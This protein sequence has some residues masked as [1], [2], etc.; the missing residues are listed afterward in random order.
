MAA[1]GGSTSRL[2]GVTGHHVTR[3]LLMARAASDIGDFLG[4]GAIIV[5]AVQT[6]GSVV[7]A[8]AV[9]A[10]QGGAAFLV[11]VLGGRALSRVHPRRG[12]VATHVAAAVVVL[13]IA[14]GPPLPA[15][16]ALVGVLGALR[17]AG[18]PLRS[19]AI[20]SSVP[21]ELRQPTYALFGVSYQTGQVLGFVAGAALAATIAPGVALLGVAVTF[22]V[23]ATVLA[24]AEIQPVA[25]CGRSP[26]ASDGGPAVIEGLRVLFR[27]PVLAL[28]G[29]LAW[30]TMLTSALPETIAPGLLNGPTT[31]LLMAASPAGAVVSSLF[32]AYLPEFTDRVV[33]LQAGVYGVSLVVAGA[34][35]VLVAPTV[36]V[37]LAFALVGAASAYMVSVQARFTTCPRPDQVALTMASMG[38]L[39][40]VLEG[41]GALGLAALATKLGPGAPFLLMGVV[42]VAAAAIAYARLGTHEPSGVAAAA[43][44][45]R[46]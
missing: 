5:L 23:A 42:S 39:I 24:R 10:A 7:G 28:L 44:A 40:V 29:P 14:A 11:G 30:V 15:V 4:L 35:V 45:V 33:A 27:H 25:V 20:A 43:A 38:A 22:V 9:F 2:R 41:A 17:S 46:P 36:V 1:S 37:G 12:L 19:A 6:S 18:A 32:V 16:L 21:E 34:T 8:G 13:V 31:G 3:S 26:D